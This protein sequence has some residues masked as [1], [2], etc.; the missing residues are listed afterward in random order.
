MNNIVTFVDQESKAIYT[1]TQQGN[2]DILK[3]HFFHY[4][5]E[6]FEAFV[7][8]I[9]YTLLSNNSKFE[10]KR[11]IKV[12]LIVGL[13]TFLLEIYKPEFKDTVKS[14]MVSSAGSNLV[15]ISGK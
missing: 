8:V 15:K 7:A 5:E 9:I 6:V 10:I 14:G 11:A 1:Q 13:I 12:S 2:Y 4:L 3:G